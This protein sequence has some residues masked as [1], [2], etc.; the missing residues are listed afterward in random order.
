MKD[1]TFEKFS[2]LEREVANATQINYI[3]TYD[4]YY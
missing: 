4:V 2:Q 1:Y 3:N